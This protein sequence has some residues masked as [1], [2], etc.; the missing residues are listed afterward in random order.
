[1]HVYPSQEILIPLYVILER[2][3]PKKL[4]PQWEEM[5]IVQCAAE[6]APVV[7]VGGL[8]EVVVGLSRELARKGETV[9]ILIPKYDCL[10][11]NN[12]S[13]LKMEVPNF[14]CMEKGISHPNTMWSGT[15]A[16]CSLHLLEAR[17]PAGYFHRGV[18]YQGIEDVQRFLYF[19][20]ACLEYLR[21]KNEP[22]DIL[23]LHDWHV[24][25]VAVL[26]KTLL[27]LPIRAIVLT[28]HNA[29]YQGRCASWDLDAIGLKGINYLTPE[30][31]QDDDPACPQTIN[32]LKGGIVYADAVNTVSPTYAKELLARK[33]DHFPLNATLYKYRSKLS[34]ILNGIDAKLWNP[35]QDPALPKTYSAESSIQTLLSAKQAARQ[36]IQKRFGLSENHR[37]WIGSITRLVPQKGPELLEEG[38]HQTL[39]LGGSFLLLGSSPVP[40]L[41]AHFDQLKKLFAQHTQV[42]LHYEYDETLSHQ[43][44]AALDFFLIPSHDEPCGLTQLI[45]MRY[46]TLPVVHAT[47]GLKDTVFDC[48]DA[49][50]PRNQRNGFVFQPAHK[51]NVTHT[52]QRAIHH[53]RSDPTTLQTM[54]QRNMQINSS[55]QGPTQAY[56]RLYRNLMRF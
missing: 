1:M 23:H 32:L 22:I 45:A 16:E 51:Q 7:K 56:L 27:R 13:S 12:I 6:F 33:K 39:A 47:G 53:F 30:A 29:E 31:L 49:S 10:N 9:E 44:Y 52:L 2:P 40:T 20:R 35:S 36:V 48:E 5:K 55:W 38:L 37:P 21:H 4:V 46:G 3:G 8:G 17:H 15:S 41:Q 34:G 26:A 50:I 11:L 28:L 19:S 14:Q 25:A 24:A 42:L 54:M 18:V 43:L